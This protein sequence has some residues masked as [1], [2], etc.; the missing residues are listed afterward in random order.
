MVRE[1]LEKLI[2]RFSGDTH[3]TFHDLSKFPWIP[4]LEANWK[5]IRKELDGVLTT[6]KDVPNFQDISEAQA[7]ITEGDRWK[8]FYL[9]AYGHQIVDNCARCPETAKLL[10]EIPAIK[11]AM[12][13]ILAPGK[14]LPEHRGLYSGVLRYHLALLIPEPKDQ[15]GIRVGDE[16]RHWEDGKSMVFDD[17]HPHEAWN[18]TTSHRVVLN[19]DF[20]RPLPFPL[21]LLNRIMIWRIGTTPYVTE[22]ARKV[23]EHNV[24]VA[25][26]TAEKRDA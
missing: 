21:S 5:T 24:R 15:C 19:V 10:L 1:L 12:F 26:M 8:T 16:T 14:H 22:A 9:F 18:D 13:S 23:R 7:A 4:K 25:A 2:T 17:T 20:V 11:V 3:V 6:L